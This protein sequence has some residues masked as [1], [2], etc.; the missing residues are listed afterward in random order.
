MSAKEKASIIYFFFDFSDPSKQT[1]EDMLR[2]ILSQVVQHN[3]S[4]YDGVLAFYRDNNKMPLDSNSL[5]TL[6]DSLHFYQEFFNGKLTYVVIDGLDECV[7][8]G[9]MTSIFNFKAQKLNSRWFFSCQNFAIVWPT[10]EDSALIVDMDKSMIDIDI[11]SYISARFQTEPRLRSFSQEK[12]D[13]ITNALS[14]QSN[15]M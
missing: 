12:K 4:L 11:Q 1:A 5:E 15:G 13:L 6:L 8:V 7:D 3:D 14:Q 10:L 2:S 9:K